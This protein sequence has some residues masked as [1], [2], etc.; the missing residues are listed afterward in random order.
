[1]EKKIGDVAATLGV[2]VDTLRYY[3]K[4]ELLGKVPRS[5]NGVRYFSEEIISRIR[6]IRRAQGMGFSL[7]DIRELLKLRDQPS[8]PKPEV[9]LMV[10]QKLSEIEQQLEDMIQLRDELQALTQVCESSTG[11]ECP[12]LQELEK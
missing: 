4:I 2:S 12:I 5:T 11:R 1:M 3:E 6:F 8:V 10:K 7:D 9:R